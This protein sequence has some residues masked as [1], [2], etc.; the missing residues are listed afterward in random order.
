[1][2]KTRLVS[3][4]KTLCS[5]SSPEKCLVWG[6]VYNKP[7]RR[8]GPSSTSC[9][10]QHDRA[11]LILLQTQA[12]SITL[13]SLPSLFLTNWS[14]VCHQI[15]SLVPYRNSLSEMYCTVGDC[16]SLSVSWGYDIS[17]DK[18]ASM[19]FA[20]YTGSNL[21][22]VQSQQ[23]LWMSSIN[24]RYTDFWVSFQISESCTGSPK[25]LTIWDAHKFWRPWCIQEICRAF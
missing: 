17:A 10:S 9:V 21:S 7:L 16:N 1:M 14:R 20:K 3:R 8:L 6:N 13:Y 11:D 12:P 19:I 15:S 2:P 5:P 22:F 18:P 4:S 25:K 24:K 23:K